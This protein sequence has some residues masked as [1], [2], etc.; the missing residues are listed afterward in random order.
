MGVELSGRAF[1]IDILPA[2]YLNRAVKQQEGA[3]LRGDVS[4]KIV[5]ITAA[6]LRG[7][8]EEEEDPVIAQIQH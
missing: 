3:L 6:F 4:V 1:L 2:V 7:E 5:P 8:Q